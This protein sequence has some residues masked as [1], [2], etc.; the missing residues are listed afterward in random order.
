MYLFGSSKFQHNKDG[1]KKE[2]RDGKNHANDING[3]RNNG[4]GGG[5]GGEKQTNLPIYLTD[6]CKF[7]QNCCNL[8]GGKVGNEASAGNKSK[9]KEQTANHVNQ[10]MERGR[11]I[12]K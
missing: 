10:E 12:N 3:D 9:D 7:Q 5:G 4:G 1:K 8:H 11:D 6:R 2:T